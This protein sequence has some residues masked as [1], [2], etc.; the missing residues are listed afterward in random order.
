MRTGGFAHKELVLVPVAQACRQ[1]G[2]TVC[3]ECPVKLG[4]TTGYVDLWVILGSYRI[5]IEA[6]RGSR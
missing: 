1:L 4:P 3:A 6:V 2:A 5:A